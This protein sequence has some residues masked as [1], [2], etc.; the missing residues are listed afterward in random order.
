[1]FSHQLTGDK[2]VDAAL[3]EVYRVIGLLDDKINRKA[4]KNLLDRLIQSL[5]SA[6]DL[7]ALKYWRRI[8]IGHVLHWQYDA[9]WGV[10]APNWTDYDTSD[11]ES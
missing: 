3:N 7:P 8:E 4:D 10:G 5:S 1:M 9:N 2:K 11:P 6:G